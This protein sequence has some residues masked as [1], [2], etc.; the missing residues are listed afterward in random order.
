MLVGH[1]G[2]WESASWKRHNL[3]RS[4][5]RGDPDRCL[6]CLVTIDVDVVAERLMTSRVRLLPTSARRCGSR[7][8]RRASGSAGRTSRSCRTTSSTSMGASS[9][10]CAGWSTSTRAS[11][12]ACAGW[13]ASRACRGAVH[14]AGQ[15]LHGMLR[16]GGSQWWLHDRRCHGRSRTQP[17]LDVRS[18]Q[19][20]V[21]QVK[22]HVLDQW[23]PVQD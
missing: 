12:T 6:D 23:G 21:L 22:E 10:A 20:K 14:G 19:G 11:S 17:Q 5:P 4:T 18:H 15:A 16:H 13:I 1:E 3:D 9:T 8:T 2:H 7:G